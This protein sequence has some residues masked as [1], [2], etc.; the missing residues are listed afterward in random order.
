[1]RYLKLTVEYDG[2]DFVGWQ[3]QANGRSV[4]EEIT[5]ALEEVLREPI[6]LIGAGRTDAGVHARGQVAG[7]RVS[8]TL[9]VG[10]ILAALNGYLPEDIHVRSVEDAP[11]GFHARYDARE[12]LYRYFISLSPSAIGRRYQWYVK[13][14]LDTQSMNDV[15]AKIVG[16]HDFESF[17]RHA[18]DVKHYHCTIYH[19]AW[20]ETPGR[21][22]YEIRGNRFLHGM[23]RALVG[24]MVD[25][26]RGFLPVSAF[27]EIM[28]SRDR[29]KAAMAAPPHGLFLEEVVY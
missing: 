7:C 2:T 18:A 12:R 22:V 26:G 21:L 3:K 8:S 10:S 29:R 4:Q 13:Y 11:D 5:R 17:C 20:T 15:A 28:E 6:N 24:T 14:D 25:V 9:G 19:S 1:M 23:V 27:A 16:E